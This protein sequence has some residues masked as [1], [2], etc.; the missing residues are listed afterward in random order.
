[1]KRELDRMIGT[2]KYFLVFGILIAFIYHAIFAAK[3]DI[4]VK[5]FAILISTT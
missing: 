5:I 1:M 2:I 4:Y 3:K